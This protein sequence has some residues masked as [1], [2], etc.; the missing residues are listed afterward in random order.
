MRSPA[1]VSRHGSSAS[2]ASAGPERRIPCGARRRRPRANA[3]CRFGFRGPRRRIAAGPCH[4]DA[5]G[6]YAI[7]GRDERCGCRACHDHV[8]HISQRGPLAAAQGVGLLGR[9][10]PFQREGMMHQREQRIPACKFCQQRLAARPAPGRR[11]RSARPP[12][13]STEAIARQTGSPRSA[14]EILR[15]YRDSSTSQPNCRSSAMI[16][17]S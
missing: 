16:R 4:R 15:R 7:V 2:V 5:L 3:T 17:R 14:R 1:I 9:Q 13:P 11:S 8:S 12:V 10:S 6:R